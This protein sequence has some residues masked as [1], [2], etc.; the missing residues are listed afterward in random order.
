MIRDHF[1]ITAFWV[2]GGAPII[3]FLLYPL[4]M[5]IYAL[6]KKPLMP[7]EPEEPLPSV[8]LLITAFNEEKTIR[9]RI[10]NALSMDYPK[11]RLNIIIHTDGSTDRTDK[12]IDQHKH[13]HILHL[14][15]TE[16]KGKTL[17]LNE[18][19]NYVKT[20]LIVYSDANSL[21]HPDAL[22]RMVRW[23]Q[24]E[25]I[26]G[27]C[28]RLVYRRKRNHAA[29]KGEAGYWNW[30]RRLKTR[31]GASGHLLGSNGAILAM[32]RSLALPLPGNQSN[33]MILP[34][35]AR[36]RGYLFP[37]E[38]DAVA[39]EE[40]AP[41]LRREYNRKRRI[42]ARG[43]NGVVFSFGFGLRDE[44]ALQTPLS[45]RLCLFFQL[46]C[47][48]MFRYLSFPCLAV[49]MFLSFFLPEG[50]TL[51]LGQCL[52]GGVVLSLL[53][54]MLHEL[55]GRIWPWWPDLSY[56][57]VMATAALSGFFLFLTGKEV[58]RWKVQR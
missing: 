44:K 5:W 36:L 29:E 22:K 24:D 56:H 40:T 37:Y 51:I 46:V 21:F 34:I 17:A 13:P 4:L 41:S 25:R 53:L 38:P 8:T 23:F 12:I 9:R 2:L 15:V 50:F 3:A 16:N 55:F 58:S 39:T 54:T 42:I 18:A 19:L 10:R 28:G 35:I 57:L 33:D 49:M 32:R 45:Q 52:W 1:V 31:E 43:L 6:L 11:D 27:V 48:K 30:D 14:K 20:P 26:G 7:P 47:K